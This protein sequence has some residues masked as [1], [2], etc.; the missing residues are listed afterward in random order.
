MVYVCGV[1][2]GMA[3]VGSVYVCVV[4]GVCSV[5]GVCVCVCVWYMV[6][7]VWVVCMCV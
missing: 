3:G 4:Y 1:V 2:Y 5:Y 6:W 7:L